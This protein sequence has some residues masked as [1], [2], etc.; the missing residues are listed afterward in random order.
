MAGGKR[1][2]KRVASPFIE[3]EEQVEG[4]DSGDEVAPVTPTVDLTSFQDDS[5]D[6]DSS[7]KTHRAL[8]ASR[9]KKGAKK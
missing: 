9:R 4:D 8:D 1:G 5:P 3:K 6:T 7:A 2:T